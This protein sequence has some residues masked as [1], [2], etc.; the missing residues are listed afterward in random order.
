MKKKVLKMIEELDKVVGLLSIS[1]F[2]FKQNFIE[3]L[4][5]AFNLPQAIRVFYINILLVSMNYYYY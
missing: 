3:Y 5:L 2:L 4:L 1:F